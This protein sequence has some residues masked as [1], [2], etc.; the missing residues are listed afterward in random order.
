[1][2]VSSRL[3]SILTLEPHNQAEKGEVESNPLEIELAE[4]LV[5][6]TTIVKFSI[7]LIC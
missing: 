7:V 1:M 2:K 5:V 3:W 6:K 4:F